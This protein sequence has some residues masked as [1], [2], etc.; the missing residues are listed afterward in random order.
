MSVFTIFEEES[1]DICGCLTPVTEEEGQDDGQSE[2]VEC[3]GA[4]TYTLDEFDAF[5]IPTGD[6][7]SGLLVFDMNITLQTTFNFH[8]E[9]EASMV[10]T[11]VV[12]LNNSSGMASAAAA[13]FVV[14]LAGIVGYG[15]R[16]RRVATIQLSEEEGTCSHFEMMPN[17]DCVEV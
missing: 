16:K 5:S 12:T 9:E 10:C 3:P 8:D 14:G 17:G 1:V 6:M 15:I 7:Y 11:V 4:G 13:M 2:E